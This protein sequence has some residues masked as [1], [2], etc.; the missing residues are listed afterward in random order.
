MTSQAS[1]HPALSPVVSFPITSSTGPARSTSAISASPFSSVPITVACRSR[2]Q[3]RTC[4]WPTAR[5]TGTANRDPVE[6]RTDFGSYGSAA[7]PV[8]I[9]PCAPKASADRIRVPMLPGLAGLSNATASRSGRCG[10]REK[11]SGGIAA[12]ATIS[13][14]LP[15]FSPSSPSSS[16]AM[17]TRRAPEA[18]SISVA[19]RDSGLLRS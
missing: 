1:R 6:A 16:G 3:S 13:G 15:S 2:A 5:T 12:T 4:G 19:H 18:A 11:S 9:S 7:C 14:M 10:M 8:T 17:A